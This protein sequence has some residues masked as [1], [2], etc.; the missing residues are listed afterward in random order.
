MAYIY[1]V[2]KLEK[3]YQIM[4]FYCSQIKIRLRWQECR[5]EI[6]PRAVLL[7]LYKTCQTP[8]MKISYYKGIGLTHSLFFCYSGKVSAWLINLSFLFLF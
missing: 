2:A 6:L 8:S 5:A 3:N 7:E 4:Y 1:L